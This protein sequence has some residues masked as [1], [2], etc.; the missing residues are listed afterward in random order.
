MKKRGKEKRAADL[1]VR[2]D[3]TDT[4]VRAVARGKAVH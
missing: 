4:N 1:R 3:E 2:V